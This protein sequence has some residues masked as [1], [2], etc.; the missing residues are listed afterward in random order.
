MDPKGKPA[1]NMETSLKKASSWR[2]LFI[3]IF[4]EE[5]SPKPLFN[6]KLVIK[7][8]DETLSDEKAKAD[9]LISS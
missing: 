1:A 8:N 6:P 4:R 2:R 7:I 5:S 3:E 9:A